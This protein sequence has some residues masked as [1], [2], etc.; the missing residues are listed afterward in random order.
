MLP[1]SVNNWVIVKINV[2]NQSAKSQLKQNYDSGI[3][4]KKWK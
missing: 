1:I 3:V 4:G 2:P